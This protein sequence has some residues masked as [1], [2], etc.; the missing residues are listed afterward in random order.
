VR[1]SPVFQQKI[2]PSTFNVY[3]VEFANGQR[4]CAVHDRGDGV[5]DGF[6]CV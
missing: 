6:W 5:L 1:A 3:Q 2:Y 4:L